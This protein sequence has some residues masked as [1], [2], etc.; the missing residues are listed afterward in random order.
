MWHVT[1]SE[2]AIFLALW[3]AAMAAYALLRAVDG[4]QALTMKLSLSLL[5]ADEGLDV[6]AAQTDRSATWWED[7]D[8]AERRLVDRALTMWDL[9]AWYAGA[10]RVDRRA[11]L[12]VFRWQVVELWE[13]AYPYVQHRRTEQPSLWSSL[14]D[15]YLEAYDAGPRPR[16]AASPASGSTPTPQS[17]SPA[18]EVTPTETHPQVGFDRRSMSRSPVAVDLQLPTAPTD[19]A[20]ATAPSEPAPASSAPP[21]PAS[22]GGPADPWL[23][24]LLE[25]VRVPVRAGASTDEERSDVRGARSQAAPA[26]PAPPGPQPRASLRIRPTEF[27]RDLVIDLIDVD[28]VEL[29]ARAR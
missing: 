17:V 22:G 7:A 23:E 20:P 26:K 18:A 11:L 13:Q 28:I 10:G 8:P 1:G 5:P 2:I 21:Q 16:V 3:A 19:S 12:A 9:A 14:T 15:L 24:A 4:R 29:P 6:L 25:A 27:R